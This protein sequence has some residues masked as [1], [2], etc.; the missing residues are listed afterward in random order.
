MLA[1]PSRPPLF[2][3]HQGTSRSRARAS[4]LQMRVC[5]HACQTPQSHTHTHT[6]T[7]TH[8]HTHTHTH[9]LTLTLTHTHTHIT[10][11]HPSQPQQTAF[12]AWPPP[13]FQKQFLGFKLRVESVPTTLQGASDY[14]RS[15][16]ACMPATHVQKQSHRCKH[17]GASLVSAIPSIA[18]SRLASLQ[19]LGVRG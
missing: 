11:T 3:C 9:S 10:H 17:D 18:R 1:T 5:M 19:L 6:H 12:T 16:G 4:D 14:L 13:R 8:N 7:H 2:P 15:Q